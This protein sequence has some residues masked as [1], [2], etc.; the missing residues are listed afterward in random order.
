MRYGMPPQ[1]AFTTQW[2]VRD[3]RGKS[4]KEFKYEILLFTIHLKFHGLVCF[5]IM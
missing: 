3:L 2:L 4:E 1:D 5:L